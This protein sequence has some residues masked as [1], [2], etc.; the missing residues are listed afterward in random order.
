[1]LPSLPSTSKASDASS[2]NATQKLKLEVE[3]LQAG[4]S[5]LEDN[6]RRIEELERKQRQFESAFQALI[7][8]G[9]VKPLHNTPIC[10]DD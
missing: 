10:V 6:N 5:E 8:S 4:I 1:V 7:D 2:I 3:R 9:M